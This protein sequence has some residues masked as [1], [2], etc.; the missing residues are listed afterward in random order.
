[1]AAFLGLTPAAYAYRLRSG[2]L[3][4]EEAMKLEMLKGVL[5][6]AVR[7]LRGEKEGVEWLQASILSLEGRR[8]V[9]LL[10]SVRGYE[11]VRN[12]LLQIEYGT[13]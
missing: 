13:F 11:H 12:K 5:E 2:R 6:E 4:Y 7:A 1:M 9:D 8:P 10:A 3:P